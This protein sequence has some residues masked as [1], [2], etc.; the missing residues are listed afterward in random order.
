MTTVDRLIFRLSMIISTL[1]YLSSKKKK[2]KKKKPVKLLMYPLME[3]NKLHIA[4]AILGTSNIKWMGI[5]S[6]K[7][8][9]QR[10][11]PGAQLAL[12]RPSNEG[13]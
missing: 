8:Q 7:A 9:I 13:A 3:H 6:T 2:K 11:H 12:Q 1:C 10:R 4:D 5:N